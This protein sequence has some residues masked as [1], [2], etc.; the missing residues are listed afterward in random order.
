MV[1]SLTFSALPPQCPPHPLDTS[2]LGPVYRVLSKGATAVAYDWL[3]HAARGN[4]L[5]PGMDPCRFASLS[6]FKNTTVVKKYKNL[7]HLTHAAELHIPAGVGAHKTKGAHVDFWCADGQ[8][9]ASHVTQIVS[10]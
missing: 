4:T 2:A 9:V 8:A 5:Q 1:S 3:S 7:Q 10:I 6:L